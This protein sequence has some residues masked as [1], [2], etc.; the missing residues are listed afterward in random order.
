MAISQY[1]SRKSP[2]GSRYKRYRKKTKHEL[3]SSPTL[4]K[5]GGHRKKKLRILGGNVKSRVL[6]AE[7]VNLTDPKTRKTTKVKLL[8]VTGNTANRYFVR[9]N[10]ITKGCI[11]K[12]DKGEARV[13]SRPGQEGTINAVLIG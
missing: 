12:T 8:S 11:I 6:F 10:I 7:I 13:T 4:T 9:R 3:G 2:T 1:K 5:V